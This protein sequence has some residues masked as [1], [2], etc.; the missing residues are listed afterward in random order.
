[1]LEKP[2]RGAQSKALSIQ[3][4][5]TGD[6]RDDPRD[7]L[8]EIFLFILHSASRILSLSSLV[9]LLYLLTQHTTS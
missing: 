2:P 9:A 4:A 5:M 8:F 1:M 7:A 6:D 3:N